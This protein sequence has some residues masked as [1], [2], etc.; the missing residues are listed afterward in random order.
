MT[1]FNPNDYKE[2][3]NNIY[4]SKFEEGDTTIRI[5]SD[6]EPV[7][8]WEYWIDG[9]NGKPKP[10]RVHD[11]SE[12]DYSALRTNPKTG[13]KDKPT[14]FWALPVYNFNTQSIQWATLK[15]KTVREPIL[16]FWR[17]KKWGSPVEYNFVV[18]KTTDDG[19][20]KYS[21]IAEP[22]DD[23]D[24]AIWE[25]FNSLTID[26]DKWFNDGHPWE[27]ANGQAGSIN[28]SS[29]AADDF[30]EQMKSAS[31]EGK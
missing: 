30:V 7:M 17:N 1:K 6:E 18:T 10:V 23:L 15:W 16:N 29:D 2:Q 25:E 5:L 13:E 4:L 27:T 22:K 14:F 9:D 31:R 12:V 19:I 11:Q 8:G 21:V 28:S 26:P 20:T 3:S 24:E